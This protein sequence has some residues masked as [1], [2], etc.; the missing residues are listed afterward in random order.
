MH[1][2]EYFFLL[3]GPFTSDITAIKMVMVAFSALLAGSAGH[4]ELALHQAGNGSPL[5]LFSFFSEVFEDAVFFLGP[6]L[7]LWHVIYW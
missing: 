1:D 5:A 4:P 7:P 2:V 6:N 3:V